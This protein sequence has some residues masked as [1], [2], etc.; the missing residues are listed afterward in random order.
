MKNQYRNRKSPRN[1]KWDYRSPRD[2]FITI[3]RKNRI[4]HFGII[5]NRSMI[6]SEAGIMAQNTWYQIP[7]HYI[8]VV[9]GEFVVMPDHIHGIIRIVDFKMQG[10]N[11]S[12]Q[13]RP[14]L[15]NIVGSYKSAVTKNIRQF[16]PEFQW[17]G[18]YHDRIIRD[19]WEKKQV[20]R[21]IRDNHLH[22]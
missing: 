14:S 16:Q 2:Y 20:E 12:L 1:P 8:G 3:I 4:P 21:Y 22:W 7:D 17:M 13:Q 19:S 9:I 5:Q 18:R 11:L 6:L 15:P 10:Q